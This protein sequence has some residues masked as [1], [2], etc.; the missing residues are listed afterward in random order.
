V[1]EGPGHSTDRGGG[2][3]V[4]HLYAEIHPYP[5]IH[6]HSLSNSLDLSLTHRLS[7][8]LSHTAGVGEGPGHAADRGGGAGVEYLYRGT[9]G[10]ENAHPLRTTVGP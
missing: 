6:T 3:G 10:Y 4:E 9:S 8:T 7:H 1:G 2:A 5:H